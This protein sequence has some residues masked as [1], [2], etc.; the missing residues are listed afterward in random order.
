MFSTSSRRGEGYRDRK[1]I[2]LNKTL[3]I[4][5][6]GQPNV[7]KS[8]LINAITNSHFL[9][10]GNFSGVT[11]DKKE[12][13]IEYQNSQLH[14]IDLPGAYSLKSFTIDEKVT[15]DF[16]KSEEYDLILNVLDS[17]HLK[18]NLYLT[19]QLLELNQ[20][21]IVVLNMVDEAERLGISIDV[22]QLS[23]ILGVPVVKTSARNKEGIKELL[24]T[25]LNISDKKLNSKIVY[26]DVIE[27]EI[28]NIE[29]FLNER[30]YKHNNISNRAV[31]VA[32]LQNSN[33]I[34]KELHDSIIWVELSSILK[35]GL[36]H[37]YIHYQE[38][39]IESIFSDERTS[40]AQGIVKEC[41]VCLNNRKEKK[42]LTEKID[43]I[44][45]H[46][47][48]GLPIFLILIWGLFNLTFEIGSIP[49]DWIDNG[50]TVFGETIGQIISDD[51]LRSLIVDGI[52]GGV[53]AVLLF[54]PNILILFLGIALLE[55]TGYMSRVA[56]LLDGFFHK[57][58]LHGKSF[59]PLVTG[60]GCSIPA[61]MSARTL[62]SE[63]D[64]LITMFIIGFMSCGAKLP[65]YVL[66]ISAFF[67]NENAGNILFAIY[68]I[69]AL[70]GLIGAKVLRVFIFKGEDEPFVMEL[71]TYRLP[72]LH[73]LWHTVYTQAIMYLRKAGTFILGVS[74][75][76]WFA[77]NFPTYE[78]YNNI[79][80]VEYQKEK[81]EQSYLGQVGEF[82]QPL[83]QPL[84]F[85]WELTVALETGIAAKE[86]IVATLGVL[87]SLGDEVDE[88][89][90]S[91]LV[92]LQNNIPIETAIAFI[93]FVMVYMPCFAASIVFVKESG[94][95]V[96]LFYLILFTTFSA[97]LLSFISYHLAKIFLGNS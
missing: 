24:N 39:D 90:K 64:R 65:V 72:S 91:L 25:V 36:E 85:G 29:Q 83:F 63:K 71:P 80:E 10:V 77:S 34:Y 68:I 47:I 20:N 40:I 93:A 97:Y 21:M 9:K 30:N 18:K 61:Y 55:T 44:L 89:S 5:V 32:L 23:N 16:L 74:I 13:I 49:M 52:I 42:S 96:Y 37:I 19:T 6:V 43:E 70:F 27:E 92:T 79:S 84:G 3:K 57:F 69:G 33:K 59:I 88:T 87:Y 15:S 62:K 45:L 58:G 50:I 76:I 81:L 17:T 75:L 1:G 51:F 67:P 8:M 66:F 26:S 2:K 35:D 54:L 48:I 12:V 38:K 7:G 4:A 46:K 86:V 95:K 94:K 28:L 56:F 31:A 78:N 60:F 11:V 82:T 41:V 73:L 14:L 22:N 53:G